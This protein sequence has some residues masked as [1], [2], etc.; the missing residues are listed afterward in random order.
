M[1]RGDRTGPNGKGPMTG[2]AAGNCAGYPVP[3]FMN[4]YG[5]QG[6]GMVCGHGYGHG[7]GRGFRRGYA[8]P[9]PLAN[10]TYAGGTSPFPD[11]AGYSGPIVPAGNPELELGALKEQSEYLTEMLDSIKKSIE[12]LESRESEKEKK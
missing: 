9:A 11:A 3:G 6:F 12:E 7:G 1:P 2:R 4:P 5:G 10:P 8:A